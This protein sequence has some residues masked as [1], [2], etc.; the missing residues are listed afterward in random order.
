MNVRL[1]AGIL[2][3]IVSIVGVLN[4]DSY[5]VENLRWEDVTGASVTTS[6]S[7]ESER[8]P[9]H[10]GNCREEQSE[11]E[12]YSPRFATTLCVMRGTNIALATYND[13]GT[14]RYALKRVTDQVFHLVDNV[15]LPANP[16]L[17]SDD[18]LL[19]LNFA[20]TPSQLT[21]ID[22]VHTKLTEKL[23]QSGPDTYRKVYAVNASQGDVISDAS[24]RSIFTGAVAVSANGRYAVAAVYGSGI[25]RIDLQTKKAKLIT[26]DTVNSLSQNIQLAVSDN[27]MHIVVSDQDT[28]TSRVQL[29]DEECGRSD[30]S[31]NQKIEQPCASIDFSSEL[32]AAAGVLKAY[33]ATVEPDESIS[34]YYWDQ[35][36]SYGRVALVKPDASRQ[37][38]QYLALGDSYSSGEGDTE[39]TASGEKYYRFPTDREESDLSKTPREKC[40]VSTRSYPYLLAVQMGLGDP[41]AQSTTKWQSVACSGAQMYDVAGSTTNYLGQGWGGKDP[42]KPRLQGYNNATQLQSQALNDFTPGRVHQIE[43]VK[44]YR[45]KVVTVT[46]GGN[47]V[48]FADRITVCATPSLLNTT[49]E[50]AEAGGKSR[51]GATI[52][53]QYDKLKLYY[54]KLHAAS[55]Y[56]AKIYVVG[57]PQF[58]NGD[59]SASC[60]PNVGALNPSEREMIKYGVM[61]LN[62]V[63][64][65]AAI[66]AGVHYVDIE[67]SLSGG[68]L[69]DENPRFVTGISGFFGKLDSDERQESFHPTPTGHKN[70]SHAINSALDYKNLLE[71]NNCPDSASTLC[72]DASATKGNIPMS[73]YFGA[74]EGSPREYQYM[75]SGTARKGDTYAVSTS[76]GAFA[77]GTQVRGVFFSEPTNIGTFTANENG[78]VSTEILIPESLPAGY[79]TLVLSGVSPNDGTTVEYEQ[80]VL[81]EG[82]N[83]NDIDEN[84]IADSTQACGPF[85]TVSSKD[86]DKDGV[87]DACDATI[88]SVPTPTTPTPPL[89]PGQGGQA[90][91]PAT[92]P[93][94]VQ[95]FKKVI[96]AIKSFVKIVILFL[97]QVF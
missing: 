29:V 32:S 64:K 18:T 9:W 51:L 93:I 5:A 38:L 75:T 60:Q 68:R 78:R 83:T 3:L 56:Q 59:A 82:K 71:Y 50:S 16:I 91:T 37:R 31:M 28:S 35:A 62:S 46:M 11:V 72:P 1:I 12:G 57:Y 8:K 24:G 85:A 58:I 45:P 13:G 19:T 26:N 49:C 17:L 52:K 47:D 14:R 81:V 77:Q 97:K 86:M 84:G 92:P 36:Q 70:M 20:A 76:T 48:G 80:I 87:D 61:Y 65:Q 22:A 40:H 25:A 66:A 23:I 63:I 41:L 30:F 34:L 4:A 2:T 95:T 90:P 88:G 55:G 54:Q 42:G 89:N 21:S 43:F 7:L 39:K 79:H 33:R 15:Y 94:L 67:N 73:P 44:K 69:C 6:S 96:I 53:N 10:F 27:G 74:G